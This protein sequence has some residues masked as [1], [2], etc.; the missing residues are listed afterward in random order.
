MSLAL[1]GHREYVGDG[2]CHGGNFLALVAMQA[3][4]DP[5]LQDLLQTP[6][7]TAK[8]LSATI[9]NELIDLISRTLRR[10][11]VT[12]IQACPFYTIIVDTT[13]D[14]TRKDQVSIIVRWV[15]IEGEAAQIRETFLTF[16]HTTD[17][18][19]KGLADLVAAWLID[20]GFDLAKIR[21]Q[22]YDGASVM[23]G[24][25]G[26]VQKLFRDIV[27]RHSGGVEVIVPFVH[28]AAHNLNLVINDAAEATG[29]GINFFGA[30]NEMFNL[31]GRS[32]NRWAELA[33]TEDGMHKLKL[34]KLCA[35]RW[36]S[37]IDAVR[38]IKNRYADILKVL[39][40]IS[41]TT[42]DAK[43]RADATGLSKPWRITISSCVSL[44][45]SVF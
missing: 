35:T 20:H 33:L 1:R 26:G 41:L 29:E 15:S 4:F 3:R 40:R 8:Y 19:A 16:I 39:A 34:K 44:C 9:Q 37:R 31:F 28:C 38:A 23:S 45:V 30:I 25:V 27:N 6:A 18:T 43:E 12:R 22:V 5:V 13:S 36:A 21:G 7:R 24:K 32:L 42:K 11:L 14:I 17:A 10:R 2:D